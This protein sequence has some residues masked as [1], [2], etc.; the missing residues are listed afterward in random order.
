MNIDSGL[1]RFSHPFSP[2]IHIHIASESIFTSPR[3]FHSHAPDSAPF[4]H[5]PL[6]VLE[7]PWELAE[8][9]VAVG[10]YA[11]VQARGLRLR[12]SRRAGGRVDLCEVR[13]GVHFVCGVWAGGD[14]VAVEDARKGESVCFVANLQSVACRAARGVLLHVHASGL[15]RVLDRWL[16]HYAAEAAHQRERRFADEVA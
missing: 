14:Q 2:G 1:G 3:N 12:I 15:I 6:P 10:H 13:A 16:E 9:V 8:T 11:E 5:D 4:E 7:Y